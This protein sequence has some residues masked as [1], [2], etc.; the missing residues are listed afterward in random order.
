MPTTPNVL[1]DIFIFS[2]GVFY[3]E[4]VISILFQRARYGQPLGSEIESMTNDTLLEFLEREGR[5]VAVA[6][7]RN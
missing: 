1:F 4:G 6:S 2:V 3:S 7:V 5:D